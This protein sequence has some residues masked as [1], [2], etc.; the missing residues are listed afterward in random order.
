MPHIL[1]LWGICNRGYYISPEFS[2]TFPLKKIKIKKKEDKKKGQKKIK[3]KT[4]DL[5]LSAFNCRISWLNGIFF[6][7]FSLQ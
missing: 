2:S 5:L 1:W 7:F 3:Q 6:L 4:G